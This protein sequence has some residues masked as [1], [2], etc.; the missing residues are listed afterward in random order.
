MMQ[1]GEFGPRIQIQFTR[2]AEPKD[3]KQIKAYASHKTLGVQ[4]YPLV[5]SMHLRSRM[6]LIPP[7]RL[8]VP[9]LALMHGHT[10]MPCIPPVSPIHFH[11]PACLKNIA[12]NYNDNSNAQICDL[13][14]AHILGFFGVFQLKTM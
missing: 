6:P 11:P 8:A 2:D 1:H 3:L 10:T 13:T 14:T 5:S 4:K 9:F 12:S 7:Q